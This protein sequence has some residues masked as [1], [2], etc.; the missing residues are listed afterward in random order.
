MGVSDDFIETKPIKT[1]V[2]D[3]QL[4][5]F[6]YGRKLRRYNSFIPLLDTIKNFISAYINMDTDSSLL[7][8][9]T[10]LLS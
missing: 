7:E 5:L 10:L 6:C 4:R 9:Y 1:V 3:V 8:F 2:D